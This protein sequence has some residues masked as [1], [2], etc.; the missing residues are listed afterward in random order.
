PR[1][2]GFEAR[3]PVYG[4]SSKHQ[5]R[6]SVRQLSVQRSEV[7]LGTDFLGQ[8]PRKRRQV[9]FPPALRGRLSPSGSS[10]TGKTTANFFRISRATTGIFLQ[11]GKDQIVDLGR[12]G[13]FRS[14]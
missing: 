2:Q 11:A 1:S 8:R 10:H 9:C 14:R 5:E 7:H 13:A 3:V 12:N 6:R 4:I